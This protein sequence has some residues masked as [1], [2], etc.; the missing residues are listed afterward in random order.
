M[1]PIPIVLLLLS[2]VPVSASP[3]PSPP[4]AGPSSNGPLITKRGASVVHFR[5]GSSISTT[6]HSAPA[7]VRLAQKERA[8]IRW[9]W[10]KAAGGRSSKVAQITGKVAGKK[11]YRR[12]VKD[13][14]KLFDVKK[15]RG[16][17]QGTDPLLDQ[18][19]EF[20]I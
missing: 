16:E 10:G 5:R 7:N 15:K 8:R 13:T 3:T 9:K 11:P 18:W 20:D 12:E 2:S 19:D 4:E 1:W 14:P 17:L 6:G